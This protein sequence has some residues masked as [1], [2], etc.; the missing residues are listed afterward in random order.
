MPETGVHVVKAHAH[1][2]YHFGCKILSSNGGWPVND[3]QYLI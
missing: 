1:P 3:W 2:T